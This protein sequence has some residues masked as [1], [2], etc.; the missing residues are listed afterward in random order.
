MLIVFYIGYSPDFNN[1]NYKTPQISKNLGGS[2]YAVIFLSKELVKLGHQVRVFGFGTSPDPNQDVGGVIYDH[3]SNFGLFCLH[4]EVDALIISRYINAF[5]H[6]PIKAKKIYIWVHDIIVHDSYNG[7]RLPHS[8]SILLHNFQNAITGLSAQGSWHANILSELYPFMTEKL[9]HAPNGVDD[10]ILELS[11]YI[12]P[13]VENSFIWASHHSRGLV[14]MLSL[15]KYILASLPN[16]TLNIYGESTD[17]TSIQLREFCENY[18]SVKY[19]GKISHAE[20]FNKMMETEYWVYPT[21]FPETFC[22]LA[23]EAQLAGC[24]CISSNSGAIPETL[25]DRGIILDNAS[26]TV[27]DWI[28]AIL[29]MKTRPQQ[30]FINNIDY[31]STQ[32]W[33]SRAKMWSEKISQ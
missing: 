14:K 27:Q 4:N 16:A 10:E 28:S 17:E 31:A 29:E 7:V 11:R 26:A 23:L 5:L 2:E 13:K 33:E 20:L 32:T 18:P 30:F 21:D 1:Q 19:F 15:W 12:K 24:K 25:G 3:A 6:C 8:A 22:M 9:F